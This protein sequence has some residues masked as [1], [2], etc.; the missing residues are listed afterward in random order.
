VKAGLFDETL[1]RCDDYDM[2][3]RTAFHG[4]KISYTKRTQA[5]LAGARPGSLGESNVKMVKT[6]WMILENLGQSLPLSKAQA[7]LVQSRAAEIKA[8]YLWEEGKLQMHKR[9]F[10]KAKEYIAEANQHLR[11][12]KLSMVLL[13]LKLAP[14]ATRRLASRWAR[15]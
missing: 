6:C 2:W 8:M 7:A 12:P 14:Q 15:R 10:G 13:G 4:G 5:Q 3:L 9:N 1:E 11:L